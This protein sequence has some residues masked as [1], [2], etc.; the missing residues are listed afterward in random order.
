MGI[1]TT[2]NKAGAF[3]HDK[4]EPDQT[5]PVDHGGNVV[6]GSPNL[7]A[8]KEDAVTKGIYVRHPSM[9]HE[10]KD[11]EGKEVETSKEK[12]TEIA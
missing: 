8:R 9:R 7:Q 12:D 2:A 11:T 10:I 4:W 5:R 6:K 1:K 3:K